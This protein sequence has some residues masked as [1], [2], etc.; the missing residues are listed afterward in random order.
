M[1]IDSGLNPFFRNFRDGPFPAFRKPAIRGCHSLD[2]NR[3]YLH[4]RE[5]LKFLMLPKKRDIHFDL[6]TGYSSYVPLVKDNEKLRNLL[7]F[8]EAEFKNLSVNGRLPYNFVS[9][10]GLLTQVVWN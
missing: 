2:S 5:N 8:I 7:L 10:R 1:P 6:N 3:K 9:Y 4:T